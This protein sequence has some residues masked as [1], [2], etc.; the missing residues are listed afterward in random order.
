MTLTLAEEKMKYVIYYALGLATAF[1]ISVIL[2]PAGD[3]WE[4]K[5]IKFDDF[6]ETA[7]TF[8][9]REHKGKLPFKDESGSVTIEFRE[10]MNENDGYRKTLM[11]LLNEEGSEGWIRISSP[12][13]D[14]WFAR[15]SR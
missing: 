1:A 2:K 10:F 14:I 5:V 9:A 13:D 7:H 12:G 11:H 3:Q 4:H 15:R 8:M 6:M